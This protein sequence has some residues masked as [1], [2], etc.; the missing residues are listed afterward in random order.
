MIRVLLI[1]IYIAFISLGLP[2]AIM[3]SAW[4]MIH[5][6]LNVPIS[7][8]G[9]ATMIVSGGTIISSFFSE[10][11]IRKFGTGKVTTF[12]V[13][14]TATGLL[15][16]YISPSF[17]WICLMGIPLGIG[18]GAVD[19]AL[20]NFVALHYK[21]RHMNWLHCF[22]G[23]GATSGPF[24]MSV[25]LLKDN[26][27]RLG[28]ATI[29]IIQ[30][31]LVVCL[32]ISLPIWRKFEA[33]NN[34]EE[35]KSSEVKVSILLKLPGA[36]A[37]LISF[38]CYCAVELTTGLWASSFLVMNNGLSTE[39]AAKWVSFYYLGITV[40]RFLSGFMAMK[41]NNKQMIRI[42]Q[43][44]CILGAAI[45]TLSLSESM[46]L[47]GLIAIGLGCAPIYPAMLHE[48]PNRFGKELSQGI[49]GIQMATAYIGS[50]FIPP[51][52][53]AIS[54]LI[55]FKFLPIFLLIF[56]G[57]MLLSSEHVNKKVKV[58]NEI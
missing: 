45:L 58:N 34:N 22:W 54:Q 18:A 24:I 41:F 1:I 53:G 9:I 3:G 20:N 37:A 26:G 56:M 21:A 39:R 2:D 5:N 11:V 32:F 42:G 4:P 35:E 57:I 8:A 29:G 25:Y 55:G 19:S 10:R 47:S 40:G 15:G 44:I 16:I 6:D 46:Q 52:F 43:V 31:I 50:T 17:I 27:W 14:L 36:K 12:S 7:Y 13:L 38:L 51:L 33:P 23:I 48:T 28:Y 49:M 30:A